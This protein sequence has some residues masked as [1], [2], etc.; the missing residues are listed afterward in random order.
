MKPVVRMWSVIG[1]TLHLTLFMIFGILGNMSLIFPV[2]IVPLNA[3]MV[4]VIVYLLS[5]R[6]DFLVHEIPGQIPENEVFFLAEYFENGMLIH[7]RPP[8]QVSETPSAAIMPRK[9]PQCRGDFALIQTEK[10]RKDGRALAQ[11]ER[12]KRYVAPP[13]PHPCDGE[14]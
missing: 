6:H 1:D 7:C 14:C 5:D 8:Q 3:Y 4:F 12:A 2:I 11:E 13:S 10:T 9:S